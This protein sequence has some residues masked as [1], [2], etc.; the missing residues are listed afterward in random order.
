MDGE[1]GELTVRALR[2]EDL[3]RLVRIDRQ[4]T[5][6]N[7]RLWYEGKLQRALAE[8]DVRI[9][10]GAEID[11]LLVGALLG[12]L[13]Y[14]EFGQPEPAAVLDTI[15]VDRNFG[16]RGVGTAMLEQLLLNLRGLGIERLRTEVSWDERELTGFLAR[17][18]FRPLPRFVLEREVGP[19][20]T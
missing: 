9:S 11:G 2:S 1:E 14:G 17:R 18:G 19:A 6:R 16:G 3:E 5:G 10:L 4:I 20:A 8:T 15:L 12:S 7:R 13:F